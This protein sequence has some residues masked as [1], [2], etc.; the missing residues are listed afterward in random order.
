MD[1]LE[2]KT[3]RLSKW[4][5]A[6]L[7][8]CIYCTIDAEKNNYSLLFYN[9]KPRMYN[10]VVYFGFSKNSFFKCIMKFYI[11]QR[12]SYILVF[13]KIFKVAFTWSRTKRPQ[14]GHWDSG[15][16]LHALYQFF[17]KNVCFVTF[18]KIRCQ[19]MM[20]KSFW[21]LCGKKFFFTLLRN[22]GSHQF[23][24]MMQ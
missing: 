12:Q 16:I 11:D 4:N 20:W 10:Y 19:I 2:S 22:L 8:E 1:H 24:I 7:V 21:K 18:C 5:N 3:G 14:N 15:K 17:N 23:T 13:A 6:R 9:G